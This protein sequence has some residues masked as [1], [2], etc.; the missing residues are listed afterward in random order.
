MKAMALGYM[1]LMPAKRQL[2]DGPSQ[3]YGYR[4]GKL[5]EV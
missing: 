1:Q 5:A 4:E 2:R 3:K